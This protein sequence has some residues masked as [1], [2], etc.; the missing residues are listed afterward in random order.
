MA[1][2]GVPCGACLGLPWAFATGVAGDGDGQRLGREEGGVGGRGSAKGALPVFHCGM[3]G[4][5]MGVKGAL[6]FLTK[7]DG[8]WGWGEVGAPLGF[9]NQKS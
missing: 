7:D 1:D 8:Q 6:G 9:L 5:G 3:V 2:R 4:S